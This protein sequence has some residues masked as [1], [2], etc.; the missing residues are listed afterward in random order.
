[1]YQVSVIIPVYKAEK[2]IEKC[3]RSL[4]E[5]T[6][7]SIEFIFVDDYSPDK[8]IDILESILTKYPSRIPNTKIL[9]HQCNRGSAAA[10]NTGRSVAQGEYIIDCDSDDWVELHMYEKMYQ[11]A[12][13]KNADIVIC[14]WNEIYDTK[15]KRVFANPPY[16]NLDC[17][18]AILSSE[19]H[20][21][22]CNKLIRKELYTQNNIACK[23]G[24][25]FCED[26]YV[27]YRL[28]YFAKSIAYINV[29]LYYYNKTNLNSYT[30]TRLSEL[31]QQGLIELSHDV[32][33]FFEAQK[34]ENLAIQKA[35]SY[36]INN[37]KSGILLNGDIFYAN[38]IEKTT[39]GPIIS[40][41]TLPFHHKIVLIFY[42][43]KF[44]AGI[45]LIRYIYHKLKK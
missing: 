15:I 31:S 41:P 5:Q 18:T 37:I 1:M 14:D 24:M 2:Y 42:Y 27:T 13:Q 19:M 45:N 26:L 4:F 7:E 21:S 6:L 10:R 25:N 36:F 30:S 16:N 22:V 28:F 34:E 20:G 40:H 39:I 17:V 11:T 43:I 3:A 9:H 23:E 32:R 35:V 44:I 33:K 8:S 12:K 38:Q 29:P